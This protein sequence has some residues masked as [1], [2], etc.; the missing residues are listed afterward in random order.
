MTLQQITQRMLHIED[1]NMQYNKET[2][3]G[4]NPNGQEKEIEKLLSEWDSLKIQRNAAKDSLIDEMN[5][6]RNTE[7]FSRFRI[8]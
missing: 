8:K 3:F 5:A 4:Q 6:L 7:T 2:N 1:V